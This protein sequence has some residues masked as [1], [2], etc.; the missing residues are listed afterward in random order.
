[1]LSNVDVL[2]VLLNNVV[3]KDI[4]RKIDWCISNKRKLNIVPVNV[5]MLVKA[6]KDRLFQGILN[7]NYAIPDGMPIVWA[8]KILKSPLREKTAGSDLFIEI[9]KVSNQKGY[10][11]FFLGAAEGVGEKAKEQIITDYKDINIVGTYSPPLGFEKSDEENRKIISKINKA[12]P[13][14][15]F[16]AF[17]APKQEKWISNYGKNINANITVSIGGTLDF[18]AGIKKFPPQLIKKMGFAWLFRIIDEPRRL[19]KR[20]LI[21]D[22]VFFYYLFLQKR[23]RLV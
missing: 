14:I 22:M 9:C 8:S 10:K 19:W 5:D 13:D 23:N 6:R 16:L 2:G 11:L 15:L 1:M 20:Y 18:V 3:K 17:G 21:D 12:N 7:N 4:I